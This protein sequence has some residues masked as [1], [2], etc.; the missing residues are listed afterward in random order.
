M[1]TEIA[2][3]ELPMWSDEATRREWKAAARIAVEEKAHDLKKRYG[4]ALI[5][6]FA[7]AASMMLGCCITGTIVHNRTE[8][9]TRQNMAIEYASMLERYKAEQAE[10][11]QAEY[12]LSGD[13]SREAF[14]NQEIDAA[15]KLAAKMSNDVQKG[16]IICNALAR[17]M[18]RNYPD[19]M[20]EVIAQPGQWMFYDEGNKFSSHDREI[21]EE[22][23][24][25]YYEDGIIPN[26]LTE[27]FLYATWS[28]SDYVL[29]NTWDFGPSTRT[30]R[31]EK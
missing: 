14:I 20:Q 10:Q 2:R 5:G 30:W 9:R 13:A 23:L 3:Q 29:R 17:V 4:L 27:E 31:Y 19:T 1:T 8:A 16:G 11:V 18:S 26:G 7:W 25:A 22:I 12:F 24:R 21:A 15:A 6:M 28:A